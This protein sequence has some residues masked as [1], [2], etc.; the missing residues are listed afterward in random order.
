MLR[1]ETSLQDMPRDEFTAEAF[2]TGFTDGW[3]TAGGVE[4]VGG[5]PV[6]EPQFGGVEYLID[7]VGKRFFSKARQS[8]YTYTPITK[9]PNII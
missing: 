1:N 2:F 5:C 9:I 6:P 7:Q 4:E 8:I 3:T